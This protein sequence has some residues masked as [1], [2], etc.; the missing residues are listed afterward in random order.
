MMDGPAEVADLAPH[1]ESPARAA[2]GGGT[3]FGFAWSVAL[4]ELR[5]GLSGFRVFLVCL[6]LGVA[7]IAAV[8]S[9]TSAIEQG[10]EAEGQSLLGGDASLTFSY[11]QA[12][13]DERAWMAAQGDVAEQISMRSMLVK[14][15]DRLLAEVK[16]VDAAYPLYG[17]AATSDGALAEMLAERDGRH[18]LITEQIVADRMGLQLGDEVRL[19]GGT[20]TFRGVLT[21]EPDK[22]SGGF[23]MGPRVMT[24][25]AGLEAT[26]ML[27]PGVL[28]NASYKLRTPIEADL[29]ATEAD[30][31]ATFPEAGSRWADRRAAAP[32]ISRFVARLGAFLT[33]VGIASLAVGGVGIGAAVRGY[34]T[35]KVPVIAAL[36]TLGA[37]AGTVFAAYLMQVGL[38]ALLGIIGGLIVGGGLV[39]WLGPVLAADLPIPADFTIY[40]APL[41][42]AA[43]YGALAAGLFTLWPLA[44]ILRVRPAELFRNETELPRPFPGWGVLV[45]LILLAAALIGSIIGLSATPELAAYCLGGIAGAFVLLRILGWVGARIAR[46]LSHSRLAEQRPVLRLALGAIGAPTAGTPGVVLALGLGLGVLAAIGQ[47][48]AN[49]QNLLKEQLPEDSPAFFFVDIQND[50]LPAFKEKVMAHE[51]TESIS[52]APMLRGM[53][54]HLNGVPSAKAEIDPAADWVLRGDRGVTYS[55]APP[56]GTVVMEGEWWDEDYAG[57]PLVSFAEEE[58]KELGLSIGSTITV[59]ILGRPIEATVASFRQVEWRGMGINFLMVLNPGALAGA[60]HTHIAT[61]YA[62]PKAEAPIMRELGR[63]MPNVTPVL[64][65]NQIK[66]VSESLGTLGAATRW[67]ALAVLLTGLAVLIGTAAAGEERR[68]AEAAILKVLGASRGAILASFALRAALTGLLAALIALLWGTVS[69]SSVITYVFETAYILPLLDTLAILF[70]GMAISLIAGLAFAWGPLRQRP[71]GVLRTAAG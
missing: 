31:T 26:G 63:E 62:E 44:W 38:I 51:G 47:I 20:F 17:S 37:T 21:A 29:A 39:A 15:E 18:G 45:A 56:E 42:E 12:N 50:Q 68:R 67:G 41:A 23:A 57:P 61:L 32:G 54:T 48:D 52:S 60:P 13:P 8:G 46:R 24:S 3:N 6:I 14:G 35:R 65:R 71:A 49:M 58:G 2:V 55:A 66:T 16:A 7:G 9:I 43:L 64:V 69:A 59:N 27:Q 19:G 33:I 30:F 40:P 36:R 10:L 5:G 70:G 34:L 4:R 28:F 22:A 53:L 1:P 25:V 11:R